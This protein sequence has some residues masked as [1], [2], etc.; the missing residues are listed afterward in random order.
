M[1]NDIVDRLREYGIE[2]GRYWLDNY[3]LKAADE[4]ERLRASVENTFNN[5]FDEIDPL[6]KENK[7]LQDAILHFERRITELQAEIKRLETE[8]ARGI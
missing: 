8:N 1:E 2:P 4:I 5:A 7:E 3:A 6:R